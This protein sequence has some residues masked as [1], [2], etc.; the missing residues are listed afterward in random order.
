MNKS[1]LTDYSRE[2]Y[3]EFEITGQKYRSKQQFFC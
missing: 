3:L 2:E 1:D